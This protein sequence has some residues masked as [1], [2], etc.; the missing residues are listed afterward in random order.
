MRKI[1]TTMATQHPDNAAKPYWN[2][3]AFVSTNA[4]IKECY[5]CFSDLGIDEYNWDWEGK[6]VDESVVD[7]LLHKL[8]GDMLSAGY[9]LNKEN[10]IRLA[11][12]LGGW[13]D[14]REDISCI[15]DELGIILGPKEPG[16]HEHYKLTEKIYEKIKNKK[17]VSQLITYGGMLRR[18]LG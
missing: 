8:T 4:E 11:K 6:F 10:V 5:L 16:H 7:R 1:P 15:E 3:R 18:S 9:Y 14:I 17:E 13:Y 12:D 2:S